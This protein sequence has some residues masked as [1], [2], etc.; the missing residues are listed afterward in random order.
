MESARRTVEIT[1]WQ[2]SD[3]LESEYLSA[4]GCRGAV[5]WDARTSGASCQ[6]LG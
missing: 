4:V 6:T 1:V 5:A 3:Y 2:I